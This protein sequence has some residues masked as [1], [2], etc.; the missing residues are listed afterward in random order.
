MY[1]TTETACRKT[2]SLWGYQWGYKDTVRLNTKK[3]NTL[4][5]EHYPSSATNLES[6]WVRLCLRVQIF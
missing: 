5:F 3:I 6:A 4:R 2:L 1:R